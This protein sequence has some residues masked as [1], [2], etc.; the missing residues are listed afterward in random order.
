MATEPSR[1][2][3][4]RRWSWRSRSQAGNPARVTPAPGRGRLTNRE[5]LL[6]G[7][8]ALGI[9]AAIWLPIWL[10]HLVAPQ[11]PKGVNVWIYATGLKGQLQN[12][13][14]LNHYVGMKPI[15]QTAFPEFA[16]LPAVL[17]ALA[18]C[19]GL[20]ALVGRR[21]LYLAAW[22]GLVAFDLYML[23]DLYGWMYDWGH[24]LD[25]SAPFRIHTFMPPVLGFKQVANFRVWSLPS[26]GGGLIILASLLGLWVIGRSFV[27]WR[28]AAP[29]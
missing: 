6:V 19:H 12:V 8:A 13:D 3:R 7:L 18:A 4:P 27:S 5:R 20:A 17:I 2:P 22:A 14:I 23:G 15:T 26:W 25:P 10:V 16:W 1:P 11:Y 21:A 29:P 24:D 28:R 9:I